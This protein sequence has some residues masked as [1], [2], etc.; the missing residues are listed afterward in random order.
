[1]QMKVDKLI[2]CYAQ[3]N[4]AYIGLCSDSVP[5]GYVKQGYTDPQY[6]GLVVPISGTLCTTLNNTQYLLKPG[7]IMHAAPRIPIKKEVVGTAGWRCLRLYFKLPE[8]DSK[9]P[10]HTDHFNV[11]V[12]NDIKIRSL[13]NQLALNDLEHSSTTYLRDKSLFQNLIEEIALSA[14][15]QYRN[16]NGGV[17]EDAVA[18]MQENFARQFS[19]VELAAIYGMEGRRFAELFQRHIGRSPIQHLTKLRID[20]SKE[21]LKLNDYTVAQVSEYVGYTDPYYFSRLFK[22]VT[23]LSP[24]EFQAATE[25]VHP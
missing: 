18:F 11:P 15:R 12:G 19:I 21:L 2:D 3:A 20:R 25:K 5:P 23:G 22:Q 24:V 17:I 9:L 14:Q 10:F 13:A 1:M 16:D 6:C 8:E 7:M 4:F